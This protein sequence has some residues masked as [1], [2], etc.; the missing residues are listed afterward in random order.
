MLKGSSG[1]KESVTSFLGSS[2]H[3][4]RLELVKS[5]IMREDGNRVI[6]EKDHLFGSPTMAAQAL[7]G[8]NTIGWDEW[9]SK[10]G[11]TLDTLKRQSTV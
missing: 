11:E 2:G 9:K 8:R 7:L 10:N 1:R 4:R 6:F 3:K 5:G